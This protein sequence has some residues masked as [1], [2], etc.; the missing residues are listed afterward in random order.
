MDHEAEPVHGRADHRDLAVDELKARNVS[1][2]DS[3][4]SERYTWEMTFPIRCSRVIP[5]PFRGSQAKVHPCSGPQSRRGCW[6]KRDRP[7]MAQTGGPGTSAL[8]TSSIRGA[9]GGRRRCQGH[10]ATAEGRFRRILKPAL[11]ARACVLG[12]D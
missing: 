9:G 12:F 1:E 6:A 2:G 5:H 7:H 11:R 10:N 4:N 8:I 3:R